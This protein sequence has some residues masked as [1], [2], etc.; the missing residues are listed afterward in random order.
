MVRHT[1]R[2][3]VLLAG[4]LLTAAGGERA[5][6]QRVAPAERR[7][8]AP[9]P[10][11]GNADFQRLFEERLRQLDVRNQSVE[12]LQNELRKWLKDDDLA[13]LLDAMQKQNIKTTD[14]QWQQQFKKLIDQNK[15]GI[16]TP[17][18]SAEELEKLKKLVDATGIGKE[19]P[20]DHVAPPKVTDPLPPDL[21]DKKKLWDQFMA[22]KAKRPPADAK[23]IADR[24]D[25]RQQLENFAKRWEGV[26]DKLGDSP[27][28]QQALRDLTKSALELNS[29]AL[30]ADD[31][32]DAQ[33]ADL[34][35][36][37]KDSGKWLNDSAKSL[38]K[39]NLGKLDLPPM[40]KVDLPNMPR[41]NLP[42]VGLPQM[43]GLPAIGM[44]RG[45]GMPASAGAWKEILL[46]VGLCVF[47]VVGW[48]LLQ[49]WLAARRDPALAGW[50]PG[51]W[52]ID[53]ARVA[54]RQDVVRAFDHLS[55]VRLGFSARHWHHLDIA[56]RLGNDD[57]RRRAAAQLATLYEQARYTPADEPLPAAA[58]AAARRD[59]CLLAGVPAA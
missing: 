31:R 28:I 43:G 56:A 12:K 33:L 13:K 23:T 38:K 26:A 21:A 42:D 3:I 46:V 1:R 5:F 57:E 45:G 19:K 24:A 58:L 22:D 35:R 10:G 44:P 47:G 18:L 40:P 11:G 6:G 14:P 51:A 32:L 37:T 55:L 8:H 16:K 29:S 4:V 9:V 36:F 53:P 34:S 30:P 49:L 50:Q 2:L 20:P 39:L 25:A 52:P 7:S 59:L 27:A 48:K 54:S 41:M 17:N 15:V